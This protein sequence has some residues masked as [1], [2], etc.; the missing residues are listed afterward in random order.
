MKNTLFTI[1]LP[2]VET[3]EELEKVKKMY[4]KCDPYFIVSGCTKERREKFD[5][6]WKNY[7]DY[8]DSHFLTQIKTNFHQRSWEMYVGNVFLEKGLSV[9]SKDEGPDFVVSDNL[10]IEC[11]A[12]TK[13]DPA[14]PDSVPR[15]FVA[16]TP[17]EIRVQDVPVDKII[18]RIT[19]AIKNKALDQYEKWKNKNWF[20]SK[21]PFVV[22]I[23]TADLAYSE[24]P[25]M[26]N[27]LKALFGF[28]YMQINIKTGA[29]NFSHRNEILKTNSKL[30]PVNY[31]INQS[32]SF[33]SGVLFS[34]KN[35]LN[36]PENIGEDCV[37]VNNPFADNPV[38]KSFIKLFKSWTA[39]KENDKI[40]LKREYE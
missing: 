4:P 15:M 21:I 31:F 18:L 30:V 19:Q 8:A 25:S 22:A 39:S 13:G 16:S 23:N 10:Y 3:N 29:K 5:N 32:F 24:D 2:L 28:Q 1:K 37:F 36:H 20:N 38:N 6:L 27:A 34:G 40:S 7:Q 11:V 26:P 12:P 9:K 35:V 33:V 14:K 17:E